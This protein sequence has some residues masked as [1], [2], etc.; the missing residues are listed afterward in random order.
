[1]NSLVQADIFFFVT[2]AAIMVVTIALV[3]A[4]VFFIQILRDVRHVSKRA[5]EESDRFLTDMEE[6][7]RFLK[8]EGKRAINVKDVVGSIIGTFSPKQKSP[9]RSRGGRGSKKSEE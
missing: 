2:T 7:R 9:K 8:K 4:L 3:I 1:M 6:L 5:R